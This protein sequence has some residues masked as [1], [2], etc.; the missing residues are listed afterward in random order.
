MKENNFNLL[1]LGASLFVFA[2]HMGRIRG[3]EPP[4]LGGYALHE[5]GV[6]IL[7]LLGGYLVTQSWARDPHP[8]RYGIRRFF[9]LWPPFAVMVLLMTFVTGPLLS[10]L[11][12]AAYFRS[13]YTAY[14]RNLRFYITYAQPGVFTH[15]PIPSSTN[16]SLWT[17]PVEAAMYFLS[18]VLATVLGMRKHSD[19]S[20]YA[21][22]VLAGV[23]LIID[24][25]LRA[26]IPDAK[27][28]FYATDLIAGYHLALMYVIGILY[29]FPQM[30]RFLNLQRACAGIGIVFICSMAS[31]TV[32]YF[33]YYLAIPYFIFSFAFAEKPVFSRLG[34]RMDLSYG[35][36]LYGFFFQQLVIQ[37][38]QECSVDCGYLQTF[39]LALAPTLLAAVIS[40]YLVEKPA[41]HGARMLIRKLS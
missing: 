29:T 11:G 31:G 8:V 5:L 35:I 20:F 17:M 37:R 24:L 26:A 4:R 25:Y 21:T 1:R 33:L 6:G 23:L 22:G 2:G 30:R 28:I 40:F 41:Q 34:T 15:L 12:A 19:K 3:G 18:P 38:L 7:F 27:I 13:G 36:F 10:D 14:L 32:Q 9:R 39:V 16:G